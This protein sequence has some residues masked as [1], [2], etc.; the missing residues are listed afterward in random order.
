MVSGVVPDVLESTSQLPP[1]VVF[2][3]AVQVNDPLL[4]DI[5]T[6]WAAGLVP[7]ALLKVNDDGESVKLEFAVTV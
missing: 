6:F 4:A 7:V 3:E 1:E 5:A 2:A